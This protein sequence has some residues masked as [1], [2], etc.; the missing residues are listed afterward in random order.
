[1]PNLLFAGVHYL[2]LKAPDQPLVAYYASLGGD[3]APDAELYPLFRAFCIQNRDAVQETIAAR[4][5]QT[6]EVGRSAVLLPAYGVVARLAG[7]QPL[8]IIDLGTSAGLNLLWDRY[9]YD[10]G[11]GRIYGDTNS[12]V[13]IGCELKGDVRPPIPDSL[14]LVA[15]RVGLDLNPPDLT[16]EDS[17]LWLRALVYADD[18]VRTEQLHQAVEIARATPPLI[19]RGDAVETLPAE[20][21]RIPGDGAVCLV[22]S[23]VLYQFQPAA[24]ERLVGLLDE[25]GR[26]RPIF[27]I[28]MEWLPG[29]P[30]PRMELFTHSAGGHTSEHL[31]NYHAH[32]T[33]LEWLAK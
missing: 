26:K 30:H 15:S 27:R 12:P 20:L 4:T 32:G 11:T 1:V 33:W 3:R 6:N 5:V 10:Y 9:S 13:R 22:H 25:W 23:H 14:P 8:A 2:L 18:A 31:A 7:D 19:V 24:I 17:I 16:D 28:S 21:D 29:N